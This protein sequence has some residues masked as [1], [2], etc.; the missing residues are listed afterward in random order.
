M[1]K[2]G[3]IERA[4]LGDLRDEV[5]DEIAKARNISVRKVTADAKRVRYRVSI[6]LEMTRAVLTST[7]EQYAKMVTWIISPRLRVQLG[8]TLHARSG[9]CCCARARRGRTGSSGSTAAITRSRLAE[10][11]VRLSGWC[12]ACERRLDRGLGGLLQRISAQAQTLPS[13]LTPCGKRCVAN[14]VRMRRRAGCSISVYE[15]LLIS[16]RRMRAPAQVIQ[17]IAI[18]GLCKPSRLRVDARISRSK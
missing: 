1:A 16:T 15:A 3:R 13:R 5:W 10:V 8:L 12:S 9:T 17:P 4:A 6:D 18:S 14:H 2:P 11:S 7:I